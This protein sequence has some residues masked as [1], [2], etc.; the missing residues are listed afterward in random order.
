MQKR[1]EKG[2]RKGSIKEEVDTQTGMT[3]REREREN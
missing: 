3:E 2:E 1:Q